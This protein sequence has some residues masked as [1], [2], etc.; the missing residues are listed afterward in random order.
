M[1]YDTRNRMVQDT[2]RFKKALELK[3]HE[4]YGSRYKRLQEKEREEIRERV[5]FSLLDTVEFN[6]TIL[7]SQPPPLRARDVFAVRCLLLPWDI[8]LWTVACIRWTLKYRLLSHPYTEED[9]KYLTRTLAG[10]TTPEWEALD[11]QQQEELFE[12]ELWIPANY[13]LF[14]EKKEDQEREQRA[15]SARYRQWKRWKAK[16]S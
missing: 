11:Q 4:L 5:A 9:Q 2:P 10:Y 14:K 12:Q 1:L 16:A 15:S 13:K 8:F 3:I 6:G 7:G